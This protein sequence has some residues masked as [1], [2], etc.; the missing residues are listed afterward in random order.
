[1][2][3][4]E[5]LNKDKQS[6]IKENCKGTKPKNV[7][8]LATHAE[9]EKKWQSRFKELK[10]RWQAAREKCEAE[11]RARK[12]ELKAKRDK[13]ALRELNIMQDGIAKELR[14]RYHAESVQMSEE[15]LE[16]H[17]ELTE[18]LELLDWIKQRYR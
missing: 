1:M 17:R 9:I 18:R 13:S 2:K 12:V 7:K 8:N 6:A 3:I 15:C 16:E 10:E 4:S 14:E 5:I 11:Y